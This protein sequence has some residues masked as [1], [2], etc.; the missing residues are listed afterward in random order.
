MIL[1]L[2]GGRSAETD[3]L[4]WILIRDQLNLLKPNQILYFGFASS[5]SSGERSRFIH[6]KLIH[7]FG[8]CLLDSVNEEDISKAENPIVF[9]DGGHNHTNLSAVVFGDSRLHNLINSTKYYFGES[10]GGM[11]A[12]EFWRESKAGSPMVPGL[13]LLKGVVVE[14]HYSQRNSQGLLQEEL[15]ATGS[16]IGIGIDECAGIKVETSEFP[17]NYEVLG[18]GL[19]EVIKNTKE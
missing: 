4:S 12:G 10:A 5:G 18:K 8:D 11:F 7:D 9:V 13:A 14:P 1:Y 3:E 2:F 19:V 17:G 6:E 15:K 16:K